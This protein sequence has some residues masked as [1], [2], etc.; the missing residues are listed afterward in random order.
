MLRPGWQKFGLG[1]AALASELDLLA[2]V[3]KAKF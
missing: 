1:L 2:S 3:S